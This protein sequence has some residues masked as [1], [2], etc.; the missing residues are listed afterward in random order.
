VT[1]KV[2]SMKRAVPVMGVDPP[3][4]LIQAEIPNHRM[5]RRLRAGVVSDAEKARPEWVRYA[6]GRRTCVN[7]C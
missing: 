7:H 5:R 6:T 2:A 3:G 1:E 4:S